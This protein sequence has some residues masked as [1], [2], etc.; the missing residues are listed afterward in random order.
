MKKTLI[1]TYDSITDFLQQMEHL[2][3]E[4][5]NIDFYFKF[6]PDK[7][8]MINQLRYVTTKNILS[9]SGFYSKKIIKL[10]IL[11][12]NKKYCITYKFRNKQYYKLFR[13]ELK[14]MEQIQKH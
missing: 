4:Y 9:W 6:V 7:S 12:K 14:K 5:Q 11:D 13:L 8:S 2:N 10:T 1:I 3:D